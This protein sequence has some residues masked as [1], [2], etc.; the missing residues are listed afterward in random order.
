M[1]EDWGMASNRGASSTV[2]TL[3]VRNTGVQFMDDKTREIA[4]P[5]TGECRKGGLELLYIRL[6]WSPATVPCNQDA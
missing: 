5:N 1:S 3:G 4:N 6:C 2:I